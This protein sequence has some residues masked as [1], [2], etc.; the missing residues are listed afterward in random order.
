MMLICAKCVVPQ[1]Y[2][3][4]TNTEICMQLMLKYVCNV[5]CVRP[6]FGELVLT[7]SYLMQLFVLP[8]SYSSFRVVAESQQLL[9][10]CITL[11]LAWLDI[12]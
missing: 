1:K 6:F 5:I 3:Y 7:Q 10:K 2:P 11:E 12:C 9:I 8:W 4:Y